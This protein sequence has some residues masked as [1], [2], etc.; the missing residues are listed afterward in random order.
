M[1]NL[2]KIKVS[3]IIPVYNVE[4]YLCKCLKSA[5]TQTLKDIEIIVVNDGSTDSSG[6]IIKSFLDIDK[7]IVL[8]DKEN[9]GLSSARNMGIKVAHGEFIAFLDSDDSIEPTF[10]EK[11]YCYAK[12]TNSDI[13]MCNYSKVIEKN[14]HIISGYRNIKNN[15]VFSSEE[16]VHKIILDLSIQ[17]YAWDKIYKRNLFIEHNIFYPVGMYYEDM[18]TT[19]RLFFYA[20]QVAY[21]N[22]YLYNYLQRENSITKSFNEKHIE[23]VL[24]A[25]YLMKEFMLDNGIYLKYS[26]EYRFFCNKNLVIFTHNIIMKYR[27]DK[28]TLKEAIKYLST[29]IS[30]LKNDIVI[31][32][33]KIIV[34]D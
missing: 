9:G 19:F 1:K 3:L 11:M 32:D 26:K 20:N 18:P 17:N 12:E 24:K 31:K 34:E 29:R 4:S 22:E 30:I 25:L 23:D 2:N 10:L 27:A 7:R 14:G 5:I 33:D 28:Y 13:V 15:T 16:A 8:I 21:L 6:T